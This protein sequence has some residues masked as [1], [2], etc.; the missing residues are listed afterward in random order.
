MCRKLFSVIILGYL[1]LLFFFVCFFYLI[2]NQYN[3]HLRYCLSHYYDDGDNDDIKLSVDN[4]NIYSDENYPE[5]RL[6]KAII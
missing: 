5:N 1:L 2:R 6:Y 4:E 3:Y